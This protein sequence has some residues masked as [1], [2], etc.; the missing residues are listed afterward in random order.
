M[1]KLVEIGAQE[2]QA[3]Y[4]NAFDKAHLD[5]QLVRQDAETFLERFSEPKVEEEPD[6]PALAASM[7]R[8]LG[9]IIKDIEEELMDAEADV[10][11]ALTD[12][13]WNHFESLLR[14]VEDKLARALIST[15]EAARLAPDR[16]DVLY[17]NYQKMKRD[18]LARV[19]KARSKMSSTPPPSNTSSINSI[20]SNRSTYRGDTTSARSYFQKQAFQ[21]FSGKSRD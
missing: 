21:K 17:E 20:S 16:S 7:E 2:N 6:Y 11:K 15:Q 13:L 18:T 5:F 14:V 8:E 9:D 4:K 1:L 3:N 10:E 19:R 12:A